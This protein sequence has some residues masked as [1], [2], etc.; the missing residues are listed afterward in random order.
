MLLNVTMELGNVVEYIDRQKI[1][2]GVVAAIKNQRLRLLTENNREV[3]LSASRL[4]HNS[5]IRLDLSAGRDKLVETLREIVNRRKALINHIDVEQLWDI[6]NTEQEWIDL[7]TMTEFCFPDSPT[8]DHESAVIRAF[9]QNR[10]Y[11]KFNPTSFFPYTVEQ[12]GRVIAQN[13]ET[14]RKKRFIEEGGDWLKRI[15]NDHNPYLTEDN[16]EFVNILKSHYLFEKES[17]D[18]AVSEPMLA[19]AGIDDKEVL[20]EILIKLRVWNENENIDLHRYEIPDI[21]PNKVMENAARL[22][23]SPQAHIFEAKRKDLT[24][25]PLITIDGQSTSDFDDALSIEEKE[26]HYLLGVH[27]ADVGHFIKK[28]DSIDQEANNRGSSIYMPDQKI[29]MLPSG[30]AEDLCSLRAGE[31]RPAISIM[32]TLSQSAEIIDFEI[33]PSLIRIRQQLTYNDVD[34]AAGVNKEIGILYDIAKKFRK[35]RLVDGALQ[36]TLPEINIKIGEDGEPKVMKTNRESPG[37]MLVSELMIMANWMMARFLAKHDMPAIY[38]CQPE[39]RDRLFKDNEGTLFQNWM[40]RKLLSRFILSSEP[41]RHS[42]L[43]LDGYVTATS[44]IRKYFDLV[45]QRQLRTIFGLESGYTTEEMNQTIQMLERPMGNVARSQYSRNRFWLLKYLEKKIGQKEVAI[46][47]NKRKNNYLILLSEYMIECVL[48]LSSGIT[49][50]S[51]DLV[52]ITI[53]HVNARKDVIS[54]FL[55]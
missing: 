6:L 21:F 11:F 1:V 48:P 9:F 50:K 3:N 35:K 45:T 44:P 18:Y 17:S 33:F 30:L 22:I 37:R 25:L 43:G 10:Q 7:A 47:L 36:I 12:V 2:C 52:Q 23:S 5:K 41:K 26:N 38:R 31:L 20:F 4:S 32:A 53:Q 28:G 39:P 54:V 29:P 51:E 8:W 13:N 27:I 49:L 16:L 46:V 40:Q 19:R 42:G 34:M 14:A 24:M 55:G 15:M